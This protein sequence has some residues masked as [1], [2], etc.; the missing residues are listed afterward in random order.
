M[1]ELS[2]SCFTSYRV[3]RQATFWVFASNC[4]PL[5]CPTRAYF[6]R[7]ADFIFRNSCLIQIICPFMFVTVSVS[8]KHPII[9]ILRFISRE[10]V[11]DDTT[12]LA[13]CYC[14]VAHFLVST[15]LSAS[16]MFCQR[17]SYI[18]CSCLVQRRS[19]T[20]PFYCISIANDEFGDFVLW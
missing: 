18:I 13:R 11:S 16:L 12:D 7:L 5:C 9:I 10:W 8:P 4:C 6:S 17:Q 19:N 2:K 3:K 14:V 1:P 20:I 15:F